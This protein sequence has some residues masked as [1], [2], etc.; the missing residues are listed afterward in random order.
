[1]RILLTPKSR[2]Y[3]HEQIDKAPDG[4]VVRIS[5]PTRTLEANAKLWAC[6]TDI[7]DQVDWHGVKLSQENWKDIFTA[8][9]KRAKVVP[10]LDGGFVV[11]GQRTSRMTKAEF[12]EL[13][14]LC[15]AFGAEHDVRWTDAGA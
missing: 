2:P 5:E 13:I 12:S 6:L 3:A 10:G 8:S 7:S 1:M 4:Y 9:L 11:L 14:E 15:M